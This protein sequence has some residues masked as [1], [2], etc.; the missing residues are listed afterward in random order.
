MGGQTPL[1]LFREFAALFQGRVH[2]RGVGGAVSLVV[3]RFVDET[4]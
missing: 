3:A 2:E 1:E 4:S